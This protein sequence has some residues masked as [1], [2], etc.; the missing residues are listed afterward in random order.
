MTEELLMV[1]S[2]DVFIDRNKKRYDQK[3]GVDEHIEFELTDNFE[4]DK[5]V[6]RA[7]E[8]LRD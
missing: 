3:V 1:I 2:Q 6:I 8:W 5:Q 7:L 4:K